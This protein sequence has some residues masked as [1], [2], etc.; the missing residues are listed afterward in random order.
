M[1]NSDS[2]VLLHLF[3]VVVKRVREYSSLYILS[4]MIS[5]LG[6][7]IIAY[8]TSILSNIIDSY[9]DNRNILEMCA[10]F[11]LL[12]ILGN[13]I[14]CVHRLLMDKNIRGIIMGLRISIIRNYVNISTLMPQSSTT[15]A[16]VLKALSSGTEAAGS[17]FITTSYTS[18]VGIIGGLTAA[19]LIQEINTPLLIIGI[20]PSTVLI[21]TSIIFLKS[22]G[23]HSRNAHA[24]RIVRLSMISR[25]ID[26]V[27]SIQA[28]G[29][30]EDVIESQIECESRYNSVIQHS[31]AYTSY[32]NLLPNIADR[33]VPISM[34]IICA[35]GL[36]STDLSVGNIIATSAYGAVILSFIRPV[37]NINQSIVQ[38]MPELRLLYK[39]II[40]QKPDYSN[41]QVSPVNSRDDTLMSLRNIRIHFNNSYTL[42][43][44]NLD[45]MQ[46]DVLYILGPNGSGKTT[47]LKACS[48]LIPSF[49][50]TIEIRSNRLLNPI[51]PVE[52]RKNIQYVSIHNVF[53]T[54]DMLN[55][56]E[57]T[58]SGELRKYVY[59]N[60]I[61]SS[62][63]TIIKSL[64]SEIII[65]GVATGGQ[66]SNGQKACVQ[67]LTSLSSSSSIVMYDEIDSSMDHSYCMLY[68]HVQTII[69]R[70][71]RAIIV[72]THQREERHGARQYYIEEKQENCWS[73]HQ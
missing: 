59:N 48:L 50:G 30:N 52:W 56:I 43:C 35:L 5:L 14:S 64:K 69:N 54:I 24:H 32:V 19:S 2:Q 70:S 71:N 57:S 13:I 1:N 41:V 25:I 45:V 20:A 10:I 26:N 47:L 29:L 23:K 61:L 62:I 63:N 38:S 39:Y 40:L 36:I 58:V 27:I 44:D 9:S 3:R 11:I 73:V 51:D 15:K 33:I 4:L 60:Q 22:I 55:K 17:I 67:L 16:E 28:L 72:V 31:R 6:T 18:L 37:M 46:N 53:I 12:I 42:E 68:G 34:F 49:Q 66:L 65:N 7:A 21:L 8:T